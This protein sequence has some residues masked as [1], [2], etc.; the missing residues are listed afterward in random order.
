[1][2]MY[3]MKAYEVWKAAELLSIDGGYSRRGAKIQS[4]HCAIIGRVLY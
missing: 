1:M 4:E 2:P 3:S